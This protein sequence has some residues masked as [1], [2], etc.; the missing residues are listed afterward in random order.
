MSKY[1]VYIEHVPSY[2]E[3]TCTA[4]VLQYKLGFLIL[5][6]CELW[7]ALYY[8]V[9]LKNWG[10]ILFDVLRNAP[11]YTVDKFDCENFAFLTS[12]KV[13]QKYRLNTCGI[14]IGD[15]PVGRHGFN[16]FLCET[17]LFYFEP[18]TGDIY[19]VEEAS[20]YRAEIVIFG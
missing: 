20:G 12:A 3:Y 4:S 9:S 19:P 11:K 7:D 8:Y 14:A 15:S 2:R 1:I 6:I 10:A 17:G 16:I 18:Q 5:N 13:S